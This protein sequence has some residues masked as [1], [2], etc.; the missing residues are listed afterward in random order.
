MRLFLGD[1]LLVCALQVVT[2]QT[3]PRLSTPLL[4]FAN[5]NRTLDAGPHLASIAERCAQRQTEYDACKQR[6]AAGDTSV[7]LPPPPPLP[8]RAS[9]AP[10]P[11]NS[12]EFVL[13]ELKQ[14]ESIT[15]GHQFRQLATDYLSAAAQAKLA[16]RAKSAAASTSSSSSTTAVTAATAASPSLAPPAAQGHDSKDTKTAN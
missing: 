1:S 16:A 12:T 2:A 5:P 8:P 13:G 9:N 10:P 11:I 15:F 14:R 4:L 7:T 3:A 6:I